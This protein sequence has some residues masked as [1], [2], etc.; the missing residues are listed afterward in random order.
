MSWF[1]RYSGLRR[2]CYLQ[3]Q[4]EP[5]S[6]AANIDLLLQEFLYVNVNWLVGW[7]LVFEDQYMLIVQYI[8]PLVLASA[9]W[10][11][12]ECVYSGNRPQ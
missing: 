6:A 5:Q 2:Y 4:G 1:Y 7:L 11:S 10:K 12:F 9:Y 8:T 3:G